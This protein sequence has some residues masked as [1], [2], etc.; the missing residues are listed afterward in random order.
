MDYEYYL[1][2]HGVKGMKW[3][4]RRY[5]RKD[6]SLTPAGKARSN[7]S[8]SEKL[9]DREDVVVTTSKGA[10]L[11]I[12]RQPSTRLASFLAKYNKR[13]LDEQQ[14]TLICDVVHD[15]KKVGDL[16]VYKESA[17]SLNVVWVGISK[18]NEGLGYGTAAMKGAI[19]YAQQTGCKQVT[20]EVPG[21]SPN[22]K[23]I[24]EKLGFRDTG[25]MLGDEGDIWGGLTKMRLNLDKE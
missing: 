17:D 12:R 21:N 18:K 6:G 15:G 19:K 4:V 7:K 23:H 10:T 14:K 22:A 24:Y 5:Q 9:S 2:H 1:C 20:L 3:G 8:F 16:Q 25:E 13:V 11:T